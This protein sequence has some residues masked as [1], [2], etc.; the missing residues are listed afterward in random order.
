VDNIRDI[1]FK[2]YQSGMSCA[3]ISE[4]HGLKPAT[5]RQWAKRYW[6]DVTPVTRE[7]CDSVTTIKITAKTQATKVDKLI[8]EAVEENTVLTAKQKDFCRFFTGNKNATQAYLKAYGGTYDTAR[9]GGYENLTKPHIKAELRRLREIRDAALD[10]GGNDVV[11][12]HMR[13][14]FADISDFVEFENKEVPIM[15]NGQPV[16]TFDP[17][18]GEAQE[19]RKNV[20]EVRLKNSYEVD[21]NLIT[22]VSEGREGVKI[23]LADKQKSLAFLERYFELDPMNVHRKNYNNAILALKNKEHEDQNRIAEGMSEWRG[24]PSQSLGKAFIDVYRDIRNRKYREYDLKG[25]RGSLKSST[26]GLFGVDDIKYNKSHCGLVVRAVKDTMRDSVY[27]TLVWAIDELGLTEEFRCTVNPMQITHKLTGQT[28]YFRGADD[29]GKIKSL[30]TPKDMNIGWVWFEEADQISPEAKRNILQSAFRG[31]S[32]GIV[33][34]SYNTPISKQHHLNT[35]EYAQ[36]PQ[37]LIHH[38]HFKDAPFEWLGQAFYDLAEHLKAT[39]PRAYSH[40]YDGE[41]TGTGANVF[42]NI[43]QRTITDEEIAKFDKIY[44]GIDWGARIDPNVWGAMYYDSRAQKLYVFREV[45]YYGM[46]NKA[47]ADQ[48]GDDWKT[49][50]ITADNQELKSIKDFRGWGF[51]IGEAKKGNGSVAYG[52]KWLASRVEIIIDP[53]RCPFAANEFTSYEQARTKNGDLISDYPDK[54]NHFL[55][56]A[57]Y[58]ME[59]VSTSEYHEKIMSNWK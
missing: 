9:Q 45:V 2:D 56:L 12:L 39:N 36:N 51:N 22:E 13:I 40:E 25:G 23:K 53:A 35:I 8:A 10:I 52:L 15:K 33:L 47:F 27:A 28:I 59:R 5:V 58:A 41:A 17:E 1:A 21:G 26:C 50:R 42:E 57:R 6:K 34:N 29:P 44:C 3:E 20:N 14:A 31:G 24:I 11:E 43:T 19:A 18:T 7:K 16:L 55:D 37:R 30:K 54:D 38:S 32:D 48:I 49:T 4:K 46:D